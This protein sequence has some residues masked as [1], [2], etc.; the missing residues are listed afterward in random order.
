[1]RLRLY[2]QSST[3]YTDFFGRLCDV[4]GDGRSLN[5]CDGLLRVEPGIGEIQP[6]GSQ[7]L[8]ISLNATAHRFLAGHRLRLQVSSGAHPRVSRNLGTGEPVLT[9]V[10]MVPSDQ[11]IYHDPNHPSALILPLTIVDSNPKTRAAAGRIADL[12]SDDLALGVQNAD[13]VVLATPVRTI[14]S[15]LHQLPQPAPRRLPGARPGQQ[16]NR[17]L[18]GDGPACRTHFR[19]SVATRCV[20]KRWPVLARPRRILFRQQ[21]FILCPTQRTTPHLEAVASPAG[22]RIWGPIRWFYRPRCTTTWWP[23]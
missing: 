6:D 14:V 17:H 13:L 20:A 10:R 5:I 1:V 11:T 23:W 19:P 16:Q 8:E 4:H 21:T 3:P 22:G 18:P 15:V 12:V 7:C 9:S 2:V